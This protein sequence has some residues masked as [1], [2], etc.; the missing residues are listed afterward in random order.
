M[1]VD[2]SVFD[3]FKQRMRGMIGRC[4]LEAVNDAPKLQAVQVSVLDEELHDELER[5]QNYGFTSHPLP[6]AEGVVLFVGGVH[7]HGVVIS[8]DDRRYRL[9]EIEPGEVA[10]YDDQGQIVHIKRDGIYIET[11]QK[12]IVNADS[13]EVTAETVTVDAESV[14]ITSDDINLGGS[15]G[16]KVA[17]VGDSVVGGVITTGS[18]KVSAA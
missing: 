1:S 17:R 18:D 10:L 13:V 11:D 3:R 2:Q 9:K 12:V 7:S 15:G 8:M 16:A 4:V 5:F 14:T 6:G